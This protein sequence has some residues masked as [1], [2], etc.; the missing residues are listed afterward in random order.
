MQDFLLNDMEKDTIGEILNISFGS[1]TTAM[2]NMLEKR[3]DITVP[4][5]E[6]IGFEEFEFN[7]FEPAVGVEITYTE[8]LSGNNIMIL[9][10]SDV[11]EI[12]DILLNTKTNPEEF[13]LTELNK[14]AICEVM[15][16]MMGASS[17]ALAEVLETTVN[18][19][20]PVTFEVEDK[21]DFKHKYFSDDEPMVVVKFHLKIEDVIE[22]EFL[23]VLKIDLAKRI[24]ES[25]K[26]DV[27]TDINAQN[28]EVKSKIQK[29]SF[30]NLDYFDSDNK[31]TKNNYSVFSS[32]QQSDKKTHGTNLDLIMT[33]PLQVSVEIGR[34]KKNVKEIIELTNG[35][36]VVLDKLAGEP[37]DIF[38]NG[39]YIAKGD[40]VV[41]DDSFGVRITEIIKNP[42]LLF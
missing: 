14:S 11:R 35:S 36:L 19:T 40:V 30:D 5:V 39:Q 2:S 31:T 1:S 22:S 37:V 27:N 7:S 29:K 24:I 28:K 18:I 32:G 13:E 42:E 26:L 10:K 34:T 16:Q 21:N 17:T 20:T 8:G 9:K 12:V 23:I 3:V 33:V 4:N 41:V 38:A 6:V 25:F 15:N